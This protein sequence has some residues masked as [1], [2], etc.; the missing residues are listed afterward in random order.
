MHPLKQARAGEYGRGF[1]VIADNIRNLADDSK[2]SVVKVQNTINS[3]KD[4]LSKSISNIYKSIDRVASVA[5]E[6]ALDRKKQVL[7]QKNKLR[8]CKN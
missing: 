3:L 1:A 5:E 8:L 6:T 7:Q 2:T 4:S